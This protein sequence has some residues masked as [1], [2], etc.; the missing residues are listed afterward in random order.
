MNAIRLSRPQA[1]GRTLFW[2]LFTGVCYYAVT[3]LA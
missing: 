3:R 2:L 1:F